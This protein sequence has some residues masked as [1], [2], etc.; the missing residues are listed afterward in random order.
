[1]RGGASRVTGGRD[2]RSE[3][4]RPQW[5]REMVHASPAGIRSIDRDGRGR[6]A[7]DRRDGGAP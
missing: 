6:P 4:P 1:V 5:P 2:H 7:G 3:R